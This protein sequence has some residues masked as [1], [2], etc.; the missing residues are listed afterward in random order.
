MTGTITFDSG[1]GFFWC[2]SDGTHQSVFI[3]QA[4][5]KDRRALHLMDRVKF[6]LER[7]PRKPGEMQGVRVE[8]T[9]HCVARQTCDAQGVSHE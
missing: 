5:V 9:G 7:N 6:D 2:E 8:Y 4:H 3:H 1:R